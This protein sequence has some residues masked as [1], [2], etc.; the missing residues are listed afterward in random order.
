MR[1]MTIANTDINDIV[2]EENGQV[3]TSSRQV[4]EAFGKEHRHVLE[5]IRSIL[6]SDIKAENSALTT[7]FYETTYKAGTG[8]SYK[9]YLMNRDGFSLLAMGFTGKEA[10]Q[11]KLKY[12][13][14]FNEMEKTLKQIPKLEKHPRYQTR[15]IATA[16]KDIGATADVMVNVY[17]VEKNMAL[18]KATNMMGNIY[19]FDS[20]PLLELIPETEKQDAP[21]YNATEV[22][23]R[24]GMTAKNVNIFLAD[25]NIIAK[26]GKG[27]KLGDNPD[28]KKYAGMRAYERNG[29]NDFQVRFKEAVFELF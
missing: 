17:G 21:I 10:L 27:W 24:V 3:V 4:A 28:A 8:K 14:A 19:G 1:Y 22:G 6:D 11:W 16:V 29:H 2:S 5:N 7:M 25:K 18:A 13:N 9:E 12:I 20:T 15:L 23:E 26:K